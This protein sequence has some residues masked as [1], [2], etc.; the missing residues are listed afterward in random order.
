MTEV[1]LDKLKR[2][3]RDWLAL[4]ELQNRALTALIHEIESTSGMIE[5]SVSDL[6]NDFQGLVDTTQEQLVRFNEIID[7]IQNF[8]VEGKSVN[9]SQVIDILD[10]T[11]TESVGSILEI[12]KSG[13]EMVYSLD[14]IVKDVVEAEHYIKEI[15]V[16]NRQTN[17]LALNAKIEAA[18]AGEAGKGFSVVADE[19]REL[20][21]AINRVAMNVSDKMSSVSEG[22]HRSHENLKRVANIDMSDNIEAKDRIEKMMNGLVIQNDLLGEKLEQNAAVSRK[23]NSNISNLIT[24]FQFQDRSRQQLEGIVGTL[25]ILFNAIDQLKEFTSDYVDGDDAL[26]VDEEWI[27]SIIN[28][29][30]LGELRKRFAE[31]ILL[32]QSKAVEISEEIGEIASGDD[33]DDDIELF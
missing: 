20:S 2:S 32:N 1:E 27:I 29:C 12:S 8:E 26:D 25:T 14:D 13:V 6:S 33:D 11:L 21:S 3:A 19:V 4:G 15:E 31:K 22:I 17:M 5:S 16:I 10:T 24:K 23:M 30:A 28:D 18:R 9:L 7:L